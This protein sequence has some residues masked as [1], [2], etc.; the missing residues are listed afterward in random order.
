MIQRD[1]VFPIRLHDHLI[2]RDLHHWWLPTQR[3]CS[4]WLYSRAYRSCRR[5]NVGSPAQCTRR[6]PG[7]GGRHAALD[8]SNR[9]IFSGLHNRCR[10]H[11]SRYRLQ[12][13][14]LLGRHPH[15]AK[16]SLRALHALLPG[17]THIHSSVLCGRSLPRGSNLRRKETTAYVFPYIS[18][19]DTFTDALQSTF[20]LRRS[21]SHSARSS[22]SSS[23][24]TYVTACTE[25]SMAACS[26]RSS[27][28]S[29]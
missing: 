26:R 10:L 12:L 14:K 25:R 28:C 6:F 11:L 29:R 1:A 5:N 23:R 4:S 9:G 7:Y 15:R 21:S 19:L 18:I 22:N 24:Y 8:G 16:Q 3:R 17:A 20:S 2:L 27:P 13:D